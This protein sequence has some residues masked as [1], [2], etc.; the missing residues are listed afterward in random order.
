M[1]RMPKIIWEKKIEHCTCSENHLAIVKGTDLQKR[2][3]F[4]RGNIAKNTSWD[5]KSQKLV[6]K[7]TADYGL[8]ADGNGFKTKGIKD[9][10]SFNTLTEAKNWIQTV[11]KEKWD[12]DHKSPII[13]S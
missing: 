11:F 6:T 4:Y 12:K 7:Y 8:W 9:K 5:D 3:Y 2:N 10:K 13:V 1:E